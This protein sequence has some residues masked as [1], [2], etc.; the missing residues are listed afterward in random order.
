MG[1]ARGGVLDMLLTN[2]SV[3][4]NQNR[5]PSKVAPQRDT[6]RTMTPFSLDAVDELLQLEPQDAYDAALRYDTWFS[7]TLDHLIEWAEFVYQT[8]SRQ[9]TSQAITAAMTIELESLGL[10]HDEVT[11]YGADNFA[12]YEHEARVAL[13]VGLVRLSQAAHRPPLGTSDGVFVL[14]D[15]R[16]MGLM[17]LYGMEP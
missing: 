1:N 2:R 5:E 12:V 17:P 15:H 6:A 3:L 7:V 11:P 13:R 16:P 4:S 9:N 8:V 10:T 14:A